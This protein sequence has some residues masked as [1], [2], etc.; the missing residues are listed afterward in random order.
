MSEEGQSEIPII[1]EA[2]DA[3]PEKIYAEAVEMLEGLRASIKAALDIVGPPISHPD[4]YYHELWKM[5][6][7]DK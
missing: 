3:D 6:P 7:R 1:D 2:K 4:N 5:M